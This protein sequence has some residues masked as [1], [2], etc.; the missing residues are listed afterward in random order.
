MGLI[1][2]YA[3]GLYGIGNGGKKKKGHHYRTSEH[4]EEH[5]VG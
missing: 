5:L 3:H 4:V 2:E 1:S